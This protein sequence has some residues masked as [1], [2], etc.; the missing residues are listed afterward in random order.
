MASCWV[1][2][3]IGNGFLPDGEQ[4]TIQLY[5]FAGG[6]WQLLDTKY[7]TSSN[8]WLFGDG[9][10]SATFNNECYWTFYKVTYYYTQGYDPNTQQWYASPVKA[11]GC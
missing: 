11:S 10:I 8:S 3:Q 7:S 9:S 6:Q 4:A 1:S 5:G 2:G